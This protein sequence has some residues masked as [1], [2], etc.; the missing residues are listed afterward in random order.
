MNRSVLVVAWLED[1]QCKGWTGVETVLD[2]G[3]SL[4]WDL[5]KAARCDDDANGTDSDVGEGGR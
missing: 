4:T 5:T 2:E 3:R 1:G